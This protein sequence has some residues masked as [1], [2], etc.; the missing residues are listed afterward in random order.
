MDLTILLEIQIL[1]L[2]YWIWNLYNHI[3]K[4]NE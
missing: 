3:D 2:A 1:C 4:K